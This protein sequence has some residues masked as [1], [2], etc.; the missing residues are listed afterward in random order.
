M[1]TLQL[2]GDSWRV[3]FRYHRQQHGVTL[4]KLPEKEATL[5]LAR[6]EE[7]LLRIKQ[8]WLEVPSGCPITEFVEKDG[9]PSV[10]APVDRTTTL[11]QLRQKYSEAVANGSIGEG[12][13]Y[14]IKI[15]LRHVETT[16]GSTFLLAGLNHSLLQSHIER[17][18]KK[19]AGVT[20]RKEITTFGA[21]W[22][23]SVRMKL[24]E[25]PYPSD[26]LKYPID[27]EPLPYMTLA[28]IERR[29]KAGS[30][31]AELYEALYL[32]ASQIAQVLAHVKSRA[33]PHW[34]Y[35]MF[36]MAA[37]TGARRAELLRAEVGDVNLRDRVV[38]LRERKKSRGVWT[39]RRVPLSKTLADALKP[40]LAE[41]RIN[42]FGDG[43]KPLDVE[44][45]KQ[46][47]WRTF[48][49][50]KWEKV[51]RGYHL[52]RHSFVSALSGQKHRSAAH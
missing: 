52:F 12:T 22:A 20:I 27:K 2:R 18:R 37:H 19:V 14:T 15:H 21:A 8:G 43:L 44:A 38:T 41:P 13:V 46:I 33:L 40:L 51:L 39:S 28:E 26:G 45:A 47:F 42:L 16:L 32:D 9:K 11:G 30:D 29:I 48:K 1:A 23:W 36:V 35:P 34:V 50:S 25:G 10:A 17:R 5:R 4:G 7:I 6:V 49:G 24:V 3:L 31:E